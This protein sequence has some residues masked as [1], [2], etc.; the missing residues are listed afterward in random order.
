[1]PSALFQHRQSLP[2]RSE[3]VCF[4]AVELR[5]EMKMVRAIMVEQGGSGGLHRPS[6]AVT[7]SVHS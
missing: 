3:M 4:S 6:G 2:P 5:L 1:M 7:V